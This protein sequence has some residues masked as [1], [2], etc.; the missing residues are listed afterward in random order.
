VATT[1]RAADDRRRHFEQ[2]GIEVLE[3]EEDRSGR[4]DLR[5]LLAVLGKREISSLLV[6]GGAAVIT[7]FLRERLADRLVAIIAPKIAG[8]GLNAVGDLGIRKMDDALRLS[9]RRITRRGDDLILDARINPAAQ[10]SVT[11]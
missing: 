9:F 11:E 1:Q 5:M 7:A 8:E 6:E 10:G 3:I 2:K 4:V